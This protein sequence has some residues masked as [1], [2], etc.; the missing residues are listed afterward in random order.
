MQNGKTKMPWKAKKRC[1]HQ[2]CINLVKVGEIYCP[3]HRPL[4]RNDY[5]RKHPEHQKLYDARWSKYRTWYLAR[6]PL[7]TN[8]NVCHSGAA[9]VD[10]I[11][12]HVGNYD[13]F[14]DMANHRPMCAECHNTKTAKTKGWG[15]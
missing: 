3:V 2:R 6:H 13:R 8:Y 9:V 7:C 15:K 12:D 11:E 4:H 5:A 14:W 1:S 10:H